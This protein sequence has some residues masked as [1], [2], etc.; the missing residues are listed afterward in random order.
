MT[1]KIKGENRV[2]GMSLAEALKMCD[3]AIGFDPESRRA[4][5]PP[6]A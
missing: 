1:G 4:A 3:G 5:K 2:P 6:S